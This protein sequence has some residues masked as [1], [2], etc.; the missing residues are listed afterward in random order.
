[1]IKVYYLSK[2]NS[3]RTAMRWLENH[4]LEYVDRK[5]TKK[6]PIKVHEI[7]K[8]LALAE[9]GFDDLINART[10]KFQALEINENEC[11]TEYLI[12]ILIQNPS[13]IKLPIII[14]E[15]KIVIGFNERE[16]RCFLSKE[17]RRTQLLDSGSYYLE[18]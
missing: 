12:G 17:Y 9:N 1:M 2:T 8:I 6:N 4:N 11:S 16:I 15:K 10:K 7:K 5:I 14:D 18:E 3:G 13:V